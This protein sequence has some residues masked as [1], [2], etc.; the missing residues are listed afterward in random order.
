[1]GGAANT[2]FAMTEADV[3]CWRGQFEGPDDAE[4]AE[5][6]VL[7]ALPWADWL[8]WAMTRWP[9]LEIG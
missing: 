6:T 2:T 5:A 9:S 8:D 1:M 7:P 3:D 4:R